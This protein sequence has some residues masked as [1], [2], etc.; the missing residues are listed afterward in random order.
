MSLAITSGLLNIMLSF[1][2]N[3]ATSLILVC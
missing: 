1:H 3:N 2:K